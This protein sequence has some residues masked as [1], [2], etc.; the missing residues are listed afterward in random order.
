MRGVKKTLK[1]TSPTSAVK[2]P[3]FSAEVWQ[4]LTSSLGARRVADF[5]HCSPLGEMDASFG[6]KGRVDLAMLTAECEWLP[7]YTRE[8]RQLLL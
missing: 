5:C 7:K 8:L 3:D 2:L 6:A 4:L 1:R